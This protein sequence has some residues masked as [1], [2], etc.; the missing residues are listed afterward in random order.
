MPQNDVWGTRY[1]QGRRM[2]TVIPS[3]GGMYHVIHYAQSIY[4]IVSI[5]KGKDINS[6][7]SQQEASRQVTQT[8]AAPTAAPL[9]AST[10]LHTQA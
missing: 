2:H 9:A 10:L 5:Q 7:A 3:D 8:Y 6:Q 4:I 1:P